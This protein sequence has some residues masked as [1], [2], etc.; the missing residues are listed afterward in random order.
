MEITTK[1]E[2]LQ[3]EW[4]RCID[5]NKDPYGKAVIECVVKGC[6][7]LDEGK[8]PEE[9]ENVAIKGSGITGAQ[10]GM[11]AH[12]ITY[13]HPRGEEFQ[14]YWNREQ[15]GTGEEDGVIDPSVITI[16]E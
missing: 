12:L 3:E 7:A 15:G 8:T 16:G 11:M 14:K 10:A 5:K 2:E 1:K 13:Y 9:S 4:Q 6:Q